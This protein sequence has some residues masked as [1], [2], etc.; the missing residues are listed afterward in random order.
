MKIAHWPQNIANHAWR[1]AEAQRKLGH[2][3]V[4]YGRKKA[5]ASYGYT[6][7]IYI[8]G[9]LDP[10]HFNMDML[11]RRKELNSFDVIHNHGGIWKTQ[12]AYY[13]VRKP[14][15]F[16]EYHGTDARESVGLYHQRLADGFFYSTPDLKEK[17]PPESIWL[18]HPIELHPLPG[19]IDNKRPLFVHFVSTEKGTS[20]FVDLFRQAFGRLDLVFAADGKEQR[21]A[22]KE[23]ELRVYTQVPQERV[24]SAMKQADV[25][26]DRFNQYGIYGYVSV[27]AMAFGKPV[28]ADINSVL[29]PKDCPVWYPSVEALRYLSQN[30]YARK[31]AGQLGRKYVGRVHEASI[32]AKKSIDAFEAVLNL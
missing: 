6:S 4:V 5:D 23:A 32:V 30:E 26:L 27:E 25:V 21:Y 9:R 3:V 31:F 11:R 18:P 14:K 16:L 17:V 29:Y 1:L 20:N 2:E 8:E 13:L 19:P 28:M 15:L 10:F 12:L 24:F 7:D 22:A